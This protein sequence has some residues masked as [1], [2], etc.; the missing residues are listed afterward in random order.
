MKNI[1]NGGGGY[2]PTEQD[3]RY[4][5]Y[6]NSVKTN[7]RKDKNGKISKT[8]MDYDSWWAYYNNQPKDSTESVTTKTI[9]PETGSKTSVTT[10]GKAQPK[11]PQRIGKYVVGKGIVYQ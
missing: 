2:K 1:Q 10:K 5:S 11:A 4:E 3:R 6:V 9:D 7:G 8:P